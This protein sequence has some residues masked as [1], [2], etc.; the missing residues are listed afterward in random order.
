MMAGAAGFCLGTAILLSAAC[1]PRPSAGPGAP[2]IGQERVPPDEDAAIADIVEIL[3]KKLKSERREGRPAWRVQHAKSQ[4]CVSAVFTVA[5]DAPPETRY[6]VWREP[7]R[8]YAAWLRFSNAAGDRDSPDTERDAHGLAIKL[9]GVEGEKILESESDAK[10]QDFLLANNPF[11]FL[12]NAR[13]FRDVMRA[14][15]RGSPRSYF[16][17]WN[18][19]RWH[20][21]EV[22]LALAILNHRVADPLSAAYYS[23]LPSRLGPGAAKYQVRPCTG[24]VEAPPPPGAGPDFLREAMARRLKDG[25]ACLDFLVQRQTDPA[26]MPIEDATVA[27][28]EKE[29]PY[30]K[31]ARIDIPAQSFDAPARR[32]FCENL[33]F[34]PWHSL[35]E[36]RPLGGLQRARRE[37]YMA[38]GGFRRV[39]NEAPREEPDAPAP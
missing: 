29:S 14:V 24:A 5:P 16:L 6:G 9:M 23:M 31:V 13:E 39:L 28:D 35:P 17:G 10:T 8:R 25:P 20:L 33:A 15:D 3:L 22:R 34:T 26:R 32:E 19:F 21:G 36:H 2:E 12:R 38:L 18:P 1:A 27:W 4:G 37:T 30:V 11:F 7:G